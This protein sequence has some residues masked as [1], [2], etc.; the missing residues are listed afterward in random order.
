MDLAQVCKSVQDSWP[1]PF[2]Y[3]DDECRWQFEAMVYLKLTYGDNLLQSYTQQQYMDLIEQ[4]N[5][6]E[7]KMDECQP[8]TAYNLYRTL[9]Q[10]SSTNATDPKRYNVIVC[11]NCKRHGRHGDVH[12]YSR[13]TRSADEGATI[14]C[15]CKTC[16]KRWKMN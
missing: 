3:D 1:T 4:P 5:S 2:E 14:F 13:Q 6:F 11:K 7:T 15:I 16:N 12:W 9:L 10:Q 8:Q